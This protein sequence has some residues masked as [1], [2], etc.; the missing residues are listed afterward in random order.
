MGLKVLLI[1]DD[2]VKSLETLAQVIKNIDSAIEIRG[3]SEITNTE[4]ATNTNI[5]FRRDGILY[6]RDISEIIY[7]ENSRN[8]RIVHT[9]S[10]D[11]EL[12]YKPCKAILEELNS[13]RFIQCSR[14]AI[15]N[16]DYVESI[17]TVNRY[18]TL[19]GRTERIEIGVVFRKKFLADIL[20]E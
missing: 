3:I 11:L 2:N 16:K 7:I 13:D 10:D 14:Y 6:R 17:D 1:V 4:E 5:Y 8:K 15:I 18:I 12:P 19:R 20:N 9:V